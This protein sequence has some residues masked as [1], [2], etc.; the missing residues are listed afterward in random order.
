MTGLMVER[1]LFAGIC[2]VIVINWLYQAYFKRSPERVD[3]EKKD[4]E[5][6]GRKKPIFFPKDNF[7]ANASKFTGTFEPLFRAVHKS[8]VSLEDKT[9]IYE[10]WCLRL[11]AIC[12]EDIYAK[13]VDSI[14][15]IEVSERLELL[16]QEIVSCGVVRDDR[17]FLVVDNETA[18]R[19][20][21]WEGFSPVIGENVR[22][23]SAAWLLNGMCIEKGV[24]IKNK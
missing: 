16:L 15:S 2:I 18:C 3:V 21:D 4:V 8:D 19:Y 9:H 10:D 22:I 13:Y 5:C 6:L 1:L 12:H 20:I 7:V 23:A 14:S 17:L 11:R 24:V